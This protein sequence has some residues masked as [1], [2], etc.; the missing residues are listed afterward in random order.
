MDIP[1]DGFV[2]APDNHHKPANWVVKGS[3]IYL[4]A[5]HPVTVKQVREL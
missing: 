1:N 4:L 3:Q 2:C 5:G